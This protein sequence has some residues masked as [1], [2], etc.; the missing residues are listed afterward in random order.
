MN[1]VIDNRLQE[2]EGCLELLGMLGMAY[3]LGVSYI[4]CSG[5]YELDEL[6]S[7]VYAKCVDKRAEVFIGIDSIVDSIRELGINAISLNIGEI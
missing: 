5:D 3:E 2:D 7:M 4:S 6:V 1:V